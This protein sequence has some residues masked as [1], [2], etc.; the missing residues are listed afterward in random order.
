M[1]QPVSISKK[2]C[3][4]GTFA[5]GKTSLIRRF[6]QQKFDEK[7]LSTIGVQLSNKVV[8]AVTDPK[9][10]RSARVK[11]ILWDLA[12]LERFDTAVRNYL[13]GAHAAVIVLDLTRPQSYFEYKGMLDIFFDIN[14]E[15]KIVFVG[16][17]TDLATDDETRKLVAEMASGYN[18]PL[19]FTSAK[20]GENV[21][22]MFL[23]LATALI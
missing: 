2:I 18:T 15:A 7:Y 13:H 23:E 9:T 1:V 8:E 11:L 3:M 22:K 4:L 6:V 16:N 14:P 10:G 21:E 12:H 19:F 5:V 20:T 17:K